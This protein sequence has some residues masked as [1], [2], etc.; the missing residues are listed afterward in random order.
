[1]SSFNAQI[2]AI[3]QRNYFTPPVNEPRFTNPYLLQSSTEALNNILKQISTPQPAQAQAAPSQVDLMDFDQ[4]EDIL[5]GLNPPSDMPGLTATSDTS[6]DLSAL[7]PTSESGETSRRNPSGRQQS[8]GGTS[9]TTNR[10]GQNPDATAANLERHNN[11]KSTPIGSEAQKAIDDA[12]KKLSTAQRRRNPSQSEIDENRSALNKARRDYARAISNFDNDL[13]KFNQ[14]SDGGRLNAAYQEAKR[15]YTASQ[16]RA[17][18]EEIA[19]ELANMNRKKTEYEEAAAR[20][21]ESQS[22]REGTQRPLSDLPAPP[23]S[24]IPGTNLDEDLPAHRTGENNTHNPTPGDNSI[25]DDPFDQTGFWSGFG[26]DPA[27]WTESNPANAPATGQTG[28][29]NNAAAPS[30]LSP[31][32]QAAAAAQ[33]RNQRTNR[34]GDRD[35]DNE[36]T[37]ASSRGRTTLAGRMAS[38]L[39]VGGSTTTRFGNKIDRTS[40]NSYTFR[41]S[42]GEN[43]LNPDGS[44]SAEAPLSQA[45]RVDTAYDDH[46]R[47]LTEVR[48]SRG[49]SVVELY[50]GNPPVHGYSFDK[51]PGNSSDYGIGSLQNSPYYQ[52]GGEGYGLAGGGR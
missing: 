20:W 43:I 4:P 9:T 15:I 51:Y 29:G 44:I 52:A 48:L 24:N 37:P 27:P 49:G 11:F 45:E 41:G 21:K 10:G 31:D 6:S 42:N 23:P 34:R 1:M 16:E 5:S 35:F 26:D 32:Q 12:Q 2:E 30:G 36:P 38:D 28:I 46:G 17:S 7:N 19:T 22:D 39:S 18:E 14:T 40:E 25:P 3:K 50:Y 33:H 8:S 47:P 13:Y